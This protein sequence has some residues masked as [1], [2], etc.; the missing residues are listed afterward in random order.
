MRNEILTLIIMVLV[1]IIGA[2]FSRRDRKWA[3]VILLVASVAGS[4]ACG[5]GI[6]FREIVEGPFGL[7]DSALSVCSGAV[8]FYLFHELGTLD[9]IFNHI[10]RIQSRLLKS[11]A[12]LFFLALPGMFSGSAAFS[13]MTSGVIVSR[14]MKEGGVNDSKI[15]G[16]IASGA[17]IGMI[18]PPNCI[19]AMIASNGAGSVLPTPFMGFYV[20]LLVLA[21]PA[22][23]L[24]AFA[25]SKSFS[26]A[27]CSLTDVKSIQT[28]IK[29]SR[30]NIVALGVSLLFTIVD[31]LLSSFVYLGGNILAFSAMTVAVL[32]INCKAWTARQALIA[33]SDGLMGVVVSVALMMGLGSFIEVSSMSGIRGYFSLLILPF[34]P[35]NV[36]LVLMGVSV[37][38]GF[39]LGESIPAFLI[40][41]AVFPIGWLANPVI[42]TGVASALAVVI[43]IS[44][45]GG[46]IAFT[47]S[48]L[49]INGVGYGSA[50]KQMWMAPSLVLA[51]GMAFVLFGDKLAFLVL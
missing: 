14:G 36:M 12:V 23:V 51:V 46:L 24:I 37:V 16:G 20:P 6:R 2:L 9:V 32:V 5:M 47:S 38:I 40:A 34:N 29:V 35:I 27:C 11:F 4:L 49:K 44:I 13:I 21:L 50:I 41:Y 28:S 22:F 30:F 18:M 7:L 42:V 1:C 25:F 19:P 43:P 39:L 10:C 33:V 8:L 45:R 17:F 15:I 31:G 48:T 26:M 3:P